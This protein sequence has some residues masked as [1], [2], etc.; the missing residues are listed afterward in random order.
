MEIKLSEEQLNYIFE[1]DRTKSI[2][3]ACNI[4]RTLVDQVLAKNAKKVVED[5]R[6]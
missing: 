2:V 6:N 1:Y 3:I 5:G 4:A